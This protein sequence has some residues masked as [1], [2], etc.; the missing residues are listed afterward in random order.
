MQKRFE[1]K[2]DL[3]KISIVFIIV[4][5]LVTVS[6]I[7]YYNNKIE[8]LQNE[9]LAPITLLEIRDQQDKNQELIKNIYKGV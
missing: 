7:F 3:L 6:I 1:H 9:F 2:D 4:I 8:N 5:S